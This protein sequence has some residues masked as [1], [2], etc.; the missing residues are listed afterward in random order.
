L[1]KLSDNNKEFAKT[2]IDHGAARVVARNL[3]K[4]E[5]LDEEIATMIIEA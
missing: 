2:L 1:E 4:F 3:E 5:C